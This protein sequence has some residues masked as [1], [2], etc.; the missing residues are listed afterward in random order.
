MKKK[1]DRGTLVRTITLF[2]AII[3]QVV[4]VI[5]ASTFASARWYQILSIIATGF[6]AI[7]NAWENNDWT[8]FARLGTRVLDALEDGKITEE[9]VVTLLEKHDEK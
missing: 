9:E 3:N 8:F 5:G 1:L 4:A 6:T 7:I 2:A